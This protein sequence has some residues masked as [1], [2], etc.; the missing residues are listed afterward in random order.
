MSTYIPTPVIEAID[1]AMV[2]HHMGMP[3]E[4]ILTKMTPNVGK[5]A[6][7]C[8]F[9]RDAINAAAEREGNAE[10]HASRTKTFARKTAARN[11]RE[12]ADRAAREQGTRR[13]THAESMARMS[14]GRN[15]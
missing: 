11:E 13:L 3:L 5:E 15:E 9:H 2:L 10:G 6:L 4:A 12:A 7:L 1:Q 14:G 8:A